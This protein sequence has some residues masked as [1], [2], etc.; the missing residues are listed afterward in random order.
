MG[1]EQKIPCVQ[2][3]ESRRESIQTS[4][5]S[6]FALVNVAPL[7]RGHVLFILDFY[8]VMPQRM[9]E[10]FLQ[11]ALSI[12]R[13]MNRQDFALGFNGAGAWSSVNHFHLQG[14]FYPQTE[15]AVNFSVAAQTR[16]ELFRIGG[17]VVKHLPNWFTTCYVLE[18]D[19]SSKDELHIVQIAWHLL[20]LL[21]T[22]EVPYNLIII[23]TVIFIFPRQPQCEN[24]IT[25]IPIRDTVQAGGLRIA[26]AELAGLIIAGDSAVYRALDE[27]AFTLIARK[28][29]SL[30]ADVKLSIEMEWKETICNAIKDIH[31]DDANSNAGNV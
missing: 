9:T 27:K 3:I 2:I 8:R 4:E 26:V 23:D 20:N 22:R 24:G 18:P 31:R 7:V 13:A 28:E 1:D 11:F 6:H 25:L 12:S 10:K 29:V 19:V 30:A 14:Y 16:E 17:T 5:K 15:D 21:Q